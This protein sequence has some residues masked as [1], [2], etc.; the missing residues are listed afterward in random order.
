[1]PDKI[2]LLIY[3]AVWKRPQITELCFMG[4]NRLMKHPDYDIQALAV[5]SEDEMKP[6]CDRYGINYV[7]AEN[8]PLGRKKN[9]GL[10]HAKEFDFE[11]MMEIGSDDLVFDDLL[12]K[13]K[14]FIN[15]NHFFGINDFAFIDTETNLCRRQRNKGYYG[16]GRMISRYVLESMDFT[17]WR[18]DLN[19][20]L[21]NNSLFNLARKGFLYKQIATGEP[22]VVDIKSPENI[23]PFNHLIGSR[24]DIEKVYAKL[25]L[26][27]VE[28]LESLVDGVSA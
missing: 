26:D 19:N 14:P 20:C 28:M 16:A 21:D 12:N 15:K 25:G 1:M 27:E 4:I 9:I 13:Y 24:Y 3:L 23:W 10:K 17:I 22:M 2:K 8:T 7:Y 5:I 18:D 11:Y 6:L